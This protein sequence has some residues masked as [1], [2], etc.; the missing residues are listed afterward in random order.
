MDAT[1]FVGATLMFK[2]VLPHLNEQSKLF[3]QNNV[4]YASIAPSVGY[5]K[6]KLKEVCESNLFVNELK[7]SIKPS[8]RYHQLELE[9]THE[10]ESV[11]TN[12]GRNYTSALECNIESKA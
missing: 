4:M 9:L 6:A 10:T 5:I 11:L 7:E 12:L 1:K 2:G 8:G 3:Q